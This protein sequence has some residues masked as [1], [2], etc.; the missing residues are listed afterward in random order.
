MSNSRTFSGV[1]LEI[2]NRMKALGRAERH[3]LRP[4]KGSAQHAPSA[5]HRAIFLF[6]RRRPR[7]HHLTQRSS[8]RRPLAPDSLV[9]RRGFEP[10]VPLGRSGLSQASSTCGSAQKWGPCSTDLNALITLRK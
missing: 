3:R 1:T 5:Y 8:C 2:L 7:S 10:L 6:L 4:S 9:E